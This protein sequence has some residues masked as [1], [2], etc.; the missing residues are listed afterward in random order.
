MQKTSC[1]ISAILISMLLSGCAGT[2]NR[3]TDP[4]NDPWEGFNRKVFAFNNSL[5]KVVRPIAVGYDTVMPDPFQRGVGNFFR[6]LDSPVTFVNQV[7]QGKFRQSGSSVGRFLINSTIGLLGFF[8]VATKMGIPYYNE[9]LGQTLAK[10][11]YHDSRYLMLPIFGP[12][13][14][15]DGVGRYTDSYYHPVGRAIHGRNEWG[16]WIVRGIDQ[17]ARYLSQDAELGQAYDPYVLM[18]D[19]WIQ[20]RQYQIYDG[21]PPMADYDLYLEDYS[22]EEPD[23]KD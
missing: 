10:W 16:Y 3:H 5:D 19:V 23:S 14:L 22:E 2:Q 6:N 18:R 17:R 1:I 7:L 12:S 9:D 11:G 20:N 21:D 8:D 15:R 13:T 4:E